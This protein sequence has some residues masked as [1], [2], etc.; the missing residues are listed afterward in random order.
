MISAYTVRMMISFTKYRI[1]FDRLKL[2]CDYRI[3]KKV[4]GEI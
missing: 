1:V 4:T 2:N 3:V